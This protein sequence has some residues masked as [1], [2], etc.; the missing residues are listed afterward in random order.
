MPEGTQNEFEAAKPEKNQT[1]SNLFGKLRCR[2][3]LTEIESVFRS[4][5]SL[6]WVN[7]EL[8]RLK[9]KYHQKCP[10]LFWFTNRLVK[11][12]ANAHQ[13]ARKMD[14]TPFHA[15]KCSNG[16]LNLIKICSFFTNRW[17]LQTSFM[18]FFIA[19]RCKMFER[20]KFLKNFKPVHP[21]H[22]EL[23]THYLPSEF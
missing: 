16:F 19:T 22:L 7:P 12:C 2:H 4:R 8:H 20:G 13:A 5:E 1:K 10:K 23:K 6:W 11:S 14:S 15:L 3:L 9:L 18:H 17:R 21:P